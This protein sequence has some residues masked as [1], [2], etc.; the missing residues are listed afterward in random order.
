M[1]NKLFLNKKIIKAFKKIIENKKVITIVF[2][3]QNIFN[4]HILINI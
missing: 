1:T 4:K 2:I 3:N